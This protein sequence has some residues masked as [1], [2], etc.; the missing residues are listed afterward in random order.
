[1]PT[2]HGAPTPGAT[3][4]V[5]SRPESS[6]LFVRVRELAGTNQKI[7][8][9]GI[10]AIIATLSTYYSGLTAAQLAALSAAAGDQW[11]RVH[12]GEVSASVLPADLST[13]AASLLTNARTSGNTVKG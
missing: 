2:I 13:V 7:T 10:V 1:V 11:L 4:Q 6:R 5:E 8:P 12:A 3:V 9:A